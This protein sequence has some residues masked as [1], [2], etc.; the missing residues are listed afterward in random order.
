MSAISALV[1]LLGQSSVFVNGQ[2]L[3]R[4]GPGSS[5][6]PEKKE[7][8]AFFSRKKKNTLKKVSAEIDD[9]AYHPTQL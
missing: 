9:E 6:L 2:H 4:L 7:M 3:S 1:P 8:V 5:K